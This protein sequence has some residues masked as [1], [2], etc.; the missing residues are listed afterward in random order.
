MHPDEHSP[1]D[2]HAQNVE[3]R[4]QNAELNRR[5]AEL[6]ARLDTDRDLNTAAL[7]TVLRALPDLILIISADGQ[8]MEIYTGEHNLLAVPYAELRGRTVHEV[9]PAAAAQ[10]I[11]EIIDRTVAEQTTQSFD[12][13]LEVADG[14][15]WFS[16]TTVPLTFA[17]R[18]CVL[19]VARDIT[20]R[21]QA[22]SEIRR[23]RDAAIESNRLKSQFLANVSHELRT[24]LNGVIG[25]AEILRETALTDTQSEYLDHLKSGA[26]ALL[27]IINKVLDFS[28]L[29][30]NHVSLVEEPFD[31]RD[32]VQQLVAWFTINNRS[33]PVTFVCQ[34]DDAIADSF[35]GDGG[36]VRQVLFN[37]IGNASK[38]TPEGIITVRLTQESDTA[39][40]THVGL[41]VSDTG[42]GIDEHAQKT[43]F[44]PFVQADGS[45]SRRFSGTGLGLSIVRTLVGLLDG[46][47]DVESA[48]DVGST[49][50]VTLPL[51]KTSAVNDADADAEEAA[52]PVRA[53]SPVELGP[54]RPLHILVAE[55]NPLGQKIIHRLLTRWG[56]RVAIA[57]DGNEALTRLAHGIFDLVLMD[58]QMPGLDGY[59]A[60]RRIRAQQGPVRDIPIVALTANASRSNREACLDAGMNGYLTKPLVRADLAAA[61]REWA[62]E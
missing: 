58:C 10:E 29:E 13:P 34:I 52:P 9:L 54:T 55:D 27:V 44:D 53:E 41:I 4:A 47:I 17:G 38:F 11:Q 43:I 56:H 59:E 33:R 21:L 32:M 35:I 6:T 24:P 51:R 18:Q 22:E 3:L 19:W 62:P 23:A 45:A 15:R 30:A 2:L 49:F 25:F 37:L 40:Q 16:G 20:E 8:Y 60:T 5:V 31:L 48:V 36:R 26:D 28:R 14:M 61:L 1:A 39:E 7:L 46:A 50:S 12:Y 42:I 57:V